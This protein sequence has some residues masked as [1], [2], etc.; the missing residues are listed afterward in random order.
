[1]LSKCNLHRYIEDIPMIILNT[2]VLEKNPNQI[3]MAGAVY[4]C[5][6]S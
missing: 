1:L 6:S 5:E 4:K 2:I 3:I